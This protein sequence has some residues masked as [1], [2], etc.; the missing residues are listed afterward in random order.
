MMRGL[1]STK[2]KSSTRDAGGFLALPWSVMD[3]AA[4][5]N[6]SHPARSL[7]LDIARQFVLDNNGRLLAS[8]KYLK[9]RGW[10]SVDTASRAKK[11][12]VDA[13][14]IY[15]TVKGHRP[16]K[17]SWYAITWCNLDNIPGFDPGAREG[18]ERSAYR[19]NEALK[20]SGGAAGRLIAPSDGVER[21][22]VVPWRGAV[23]RQTAVAV[24]P[25]HGNHLEIPSPQSQKSGG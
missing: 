20:P 1:K 6:L 24:T 25:A 9:T 22:N 19:K 17:A 18:F 12:L 16:N 23:R 15:E 7:L 2:V 8:S 10:T 21:R 3:S 4:Y 11:E 14:L 5:K 13:G